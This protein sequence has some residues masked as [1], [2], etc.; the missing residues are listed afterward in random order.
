MSEIASLVEQLENGS[1]DIASCLS[2]RPDLSR[3]DQFQL[4]LA[5]QKYRVQRREP[6]S[7][8]HYAQILPWLASDPQRQQQLIASEFALL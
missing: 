7:A 6:S 1:T 5:D 2:S 3:D 4:V 8:E